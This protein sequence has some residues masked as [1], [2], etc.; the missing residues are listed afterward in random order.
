MKRQSLLGLILLSVSLFAA[1]AQAELVVED[2]WV[3]AA[4]P[5][6]KTTALYMRIK[7]NGEKDIYLTGVSSEIAGSA[8]FHRTFESNG[9]AAMHH[10]DRVKVASG[11]QVQF[12]PGGLHVMLMRL[13]SGLKVGD[14]VAVKLQ[15]SDGREIQIKAKVKTQ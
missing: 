6:Q 2:A 10:V 9:M 7:N 3:R 13:K 4:L 1:K 15:L 14:E 11:Q 12:K 8:M 5:V